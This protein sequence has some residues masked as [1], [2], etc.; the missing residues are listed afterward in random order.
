MDGRE[1]GTAGCIGAV[2]TTWME[3]RRVRLVVSG[4]YT[5]RGWKRER[6]GWFNGTAHSTQMEERKVRL[7]EWGIT[8]KLNG[9]EKG[10]AG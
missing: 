2:H 3:E 9:R 6:N 7:V 4:P 10:T 5:Q 8:P 1:K